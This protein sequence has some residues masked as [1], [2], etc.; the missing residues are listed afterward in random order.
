MENEN[1][2]AVHGKT[3]SYFAKKGRKTI[4]IIH[5]P[6]LAFS[7]SYVYWSENQNET[8]SPFIHNNANKST[9]FY[10]TLELFHL[11]KNV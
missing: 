2:I 8:H 1:I 9:N 11:E 5:K 10:G 7:I 6:D 3:D 4:S